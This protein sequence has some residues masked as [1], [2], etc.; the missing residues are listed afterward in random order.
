MFRNE[1]SLRSYDHQSSS[2]ISS[3][4]SQDLV[5]SDSGHSSG[6]Q[7]LPSSKSVSFAA[8]DNS[9]SGI[10]SSDNEPSQAE[11]V[12]QNLAASKP[13]D[14]SK[15]A[16]S[17]VPDPSPD[18]SPSPARRD[19]PPTS[20]PPEFRAEFSFSEVRLQEALAKSTRADIN[21]LVDPDSSGDLSGRDSLPTPTPQVITES[22]SMEDRVRQLET[23]L[24]RERQKI[25]ERDKT[26]A[27]LEQKL[28]KYQIDEL[29]GVMD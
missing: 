10:V 24:E 4:N 7:Q 15:P 13:T 11:A 9:S 14:C 17:I 8:A 2:G 26:I 21:S 29:K 12:S 3:A 1:M 22:V 6:S 5:T 18:K 28:M 27:E 20:P 25:K 16:Q 19:T 23:E